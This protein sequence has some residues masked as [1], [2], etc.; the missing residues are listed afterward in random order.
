MLEIMIFK[1]HFTSAFILLPL[2]ALFT[3][4]CGKVDITVPYKNPPRL[5]LALKSNNIAVFPEKN[6]KAEDKELINILNSKIEES[7]LNGGTFKPVDLSSES[8]RQHLIENSLN[9]ATGYNNKE[10][11]QIGK[12]LN[13][14]LLIIPSLTLNRQLSNTSRSRTIRVGT[15]RYEFIIVDGRRVRQEIKREKV[16]QDTYETKTLNIS[17]QVKLVNVET[18]AVESSFS[19]RTI[20]SYR[21]E[22]VVDRGAFGGMGL[23]ILG[24]FL[25]RDP[26]EHPSEDSF[27]DDFIEKVKKRTVNEITA[28]TYQFDTKIYDS[29]D[30]E[31]GYRYA[32]QGNW[33]KAAN[34]WQIAL[35]E[36][37]DNYKC[38]TN[39]G[40]AYFALG[41]FERSELYLQQAYELED[42]EDIFALSQKVSE[43]KNEK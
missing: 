15:G 28:E 18:G 20:P 3:S 27:I 9:N 43:L 22:I 39:L 26:T 24:T 19:L 6:I 13:V 40:A 11:L 33:E 29:G 17:S 5:K 34:F 23:N 14:S 41:D 32:V 2:L 21:S 10:L 7:F 4:S 38:L 12:G 25:N 31:K 36:E 1:N 16:V 35:G 30:L 37:N 42:D 8:K